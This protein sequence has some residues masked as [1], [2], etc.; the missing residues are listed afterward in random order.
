MQP[1]LTVSAS[2]DTTASPSPSLASPAVT[3]PSFAV[4]PPQVLYAKVAFAER[5]NS[6]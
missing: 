2:P 6:F 5:V 4:L 1:S 3:S